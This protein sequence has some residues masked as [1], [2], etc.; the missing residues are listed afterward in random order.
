LLTCKQFLQ[1]LS[2]FLD[3]SCDPTLR[4]DIEKHLDE[5][6][7]CFVI[8]DTTKKTIRVFKGMQPRALPEAIRSR[9]MQVIESRCRRDTRRAD[10]GPGVGAHSPE[11]K[12][13]S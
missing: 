10:G 12:P 5:C 7:N 4:A 11:S 6:P 13:L 2:D 8:C 3:E 9:L 1:E